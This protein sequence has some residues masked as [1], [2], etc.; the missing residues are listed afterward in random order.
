GIPEASIPPSPGR[1]YDEIVDGIERG[2]IRGLWVVGTNP[3]HSWI[4]RE[5]L[6]EAFAR[7]DLLVVE[8]MYHPTETARL[9]HLVLPAAGWGEKDGTFI[10]S[11]RRIG[12]TRRVV[13]P[14]GEARS[15]FEIFR[16]IA[17]AAGC[18]QLFEEWKSPARV[19]E[20]LKRLSAG[21]PFDF[22]GV[23]SLDSLD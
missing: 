1:S 9:A 4:G 3:A 6:D 14:P 12:R 19:F 22:S 20:I 13:D 23:P 5:G 15:D 10:N 21:R 16:G 8:D 2:E 7:L 18:A 17:A 11:E